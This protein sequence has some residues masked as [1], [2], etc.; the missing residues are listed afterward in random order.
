MIKKSTLLIL[1]FSFVACVCFAAAQSSQPPQEQQ[2]GSPT[3]QMQ[4]ISGIVEKVDH[5][6]MTI[7]IRDETSNQTQEC[8]LSEATSVTRGSGAA[9]HMDLKKGDRV[10]LEVDSQNVATSIKIEDQL[11]Q[12]NKD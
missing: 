6:N 11:K 2:S 12:E 5:E 10:S 4:Q 8:N 9:S 3:T 1:L 7:T